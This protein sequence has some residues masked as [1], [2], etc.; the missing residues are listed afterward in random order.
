MKQQQTALGRLKVLLLAIGLASTAQ[1]S[2]ASD[3]FDKPV[4]GGAPLEQLRASS[5][6]GGVSL[7]RQRS[8]QPAA[9]YQLGMLSR[10]YGPTTAEREAG[11][12]TPQSNIGID[13]MQ[14]AA[15][16]PG[17]FGS[18]ALSMRNFP[19]SARWA[20]VYEAI[21]GCSAG[22]ACERKSAAF[23]AIIDVVRGKAFS[24]K[25]SFVNSSVNRLI[26]YK[27]D[28]AVYGKF[29]YWA[30]P[31]EILDHRAGD[32]EDFAILKMTALLR[33]GIPAQSMSLVVLQ[34]RRRNFFHAV[35]SV[36]T[37]SGTFIL[38]NLSNLVLRDSDLPDYQPLYSVSTNRAWIHGA[39]SGAAQVAEIKGGFASVAPG[40]GFQ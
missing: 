26:A 23:A 10:G 34:D 16:I 31:L 22:S 29:D 12:S 36:S 14:T 27:K 11:P 5:Y 9:A 28:G 19:A 32:C 24:D 20:P 15:I 7:E 39:K 37:G 35:L 38:D 30:K 2:L 18:V 4:P 8:W 6:L 17:V 25:L 33:A 3:N 13:S 40:E 1:P 21:V